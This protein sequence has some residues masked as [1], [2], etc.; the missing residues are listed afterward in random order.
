MEA[1]RTICHFQ[2]CVPADQMKHN[3]LID[4]YKPPTLHDFTSLSNILG[5]VMEPQISLDFTLMCF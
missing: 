2:N 5:R 3:L 4:E 1:R